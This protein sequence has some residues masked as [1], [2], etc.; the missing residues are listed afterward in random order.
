[1]TPWRDHVDAAAVI[2]LG[3][4]EFGN[5]YADVVFGHHSPTGHLPVSMPMSYDDTIE[6]VETDAWYSEGMATG[7]R[8]KDFKTAYP[9]GHG[10]SYST[11]EYSGATQQACKHEGYVT[12]VSI[13]VKNTGSRE[14]AVTPQLYLEFPDEAAYPAPVLKGFSKHTI[15]VGATET[16]T[17]PL[18]WRDVSYWE[19]NKYVMVDALRAH[20]GA[21]SAD[22][23]T[24]IPLTISTSVVV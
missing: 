9:F 11:F 18:A 15:Q 7:Y 20:I 4:Q 5:A 22:I 24:S 8:N 23:Q 2:F 21:S 13:K 1:L 6:P 19:D 3:G 10:L 17:F 16:I 12:C 14:A